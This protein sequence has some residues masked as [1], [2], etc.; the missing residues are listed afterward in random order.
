METT[1]IR[2]TN[3][4]YVQKGKGPA[5][6]LVHGFP[7]DHRIWLEQIDALAEHFR[8]IAV[9]L[10][11]FGMSL[12]TEAFTIDSMADELAEFIR[13]VGA[14]PCTLA[15]LSMGG[16]V[17]LSLAARHPDVLKGLVIVCSKS[18]ADTPQGRQGRQAMAETAQKH[19]AKPVADAM[20]PRMFCENTLRNRPELVKRLRD[21]MENCPPATIAN[22]CFAM[23]DRADRTPDL[24]KLK[25]PVMVILGE[26]DAIIPASMGQQ[27]VQGCQRGEFVLIPGAGHL[28]TMEE[29]AAVNSAIARFAASV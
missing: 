23:R 17:S 5:I 9:D 8:V 10:K 12:S 4:R 26:K 13:I 24:P 22:A 7:L 29:P 16:Y 6:V 3:W 25:M 19:G 2:N 1:T 20:M 18:E 14:A 27:M 28:A 11:G 21:I 15:G